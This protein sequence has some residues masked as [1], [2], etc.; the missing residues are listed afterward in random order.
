MSDTAHLEASAPPN[1]ETIGFDDVIS[2]LKA[3]VRDFAR[4]PGFGLFFAGFYVIMGIVIYLQLDVL[5]QSY[6]II[7]VALG[8]PLLAPFLAVGLYEVSR[9]LEADEPLDWAQVLGVVFNQKDRQ[10]PSI[11]MV[12]IMIFMFWVFVAHLVFAIFMGLEPLTNITTNWQD[13][14]L[15]RNGITMLVV[16]T[17]V[18]A[19]L[20]FCLFSLTVTS[21]PLL[22]DRELDFITAMI[23]SFQSVLQNLLP[24]VSWG[25]IIS[26][27]M[28]IGMLPFFLGLFVVLPI[29]GHATWHLYRRV[30]SFED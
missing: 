2:A 19:V 5:D 10:F 23:Y 13:A 26:V 27:L 21:L 22:L 3:G 29:L 18:G 9:R 17:A 6:W 14:L 12:I 11:A 28:L 7:P 4:A 24:M 30:M 16:G 20:A 8:F 15:N 1:I 25:V